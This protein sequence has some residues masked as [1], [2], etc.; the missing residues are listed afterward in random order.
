VVRWKTS[1]ALF[2]ARLHEALQEQWDAHRGRLEAL[3]GKALD[4]IGAALDSPDEAT[5]FRA[6]V[7]V[8]RLAGERPKGATTEN[9][10]TLGWAYSNIGG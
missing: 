6:A 8:L 1:D 10:V 5:S 3:Q 7:Q 2:V 4:V 9:G